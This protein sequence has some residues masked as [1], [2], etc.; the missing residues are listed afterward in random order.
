MKIRLGY[1]AISNK[2]GKKVTSSSAVTFANYKKI[3]TEEKRKEKLINTAFSNLTGLQR[4]LKYNIENDI[5]FYRITSKLIP[6]ETHPEVE[7][8]GYYEKFKKDYEYI[9]KLIKESNMRV[10]THLDQF[11]VINSTSQQVV[12]ST[13]R[14]LLNHVKLFENI[15]YDE[16]KMV[17]HVGGAAG[18]N[19][20]GLERFVK[21]FR[22]YPESIKER[23]IVE[24]D[25]KIYTAKEVLSLCNA[26]DIPMVL[27]VHHHNCNNKG[28]DIGSFTEDIF[29]TWNKTSL[30]PKIHFS[31]PREFVNDRKHA[32]Y[33]DANDF[34]DFLE[35]VKH[36]N[37]DF[38]VMLECKE[39]D[40]ALYKL[41]ED[42]KKIKPQYEWKDISTI[43]VN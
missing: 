14:V 10:D 18:G 19:E 13:E 37:R 3:E 35:K 31:S 38:D 30:V 12:E 16:G 28:E 9:G 24:N 4:I 17:I 34:V 2:L 25:D 29:N 23:L 6:L 21:N 39:K 43:I 8:Y 32:D 26:L 41:S 15:N 40:L 33:I 22:E 36:L 20:A 27:D 5:H 42:I 1:V 7:Y 11:N